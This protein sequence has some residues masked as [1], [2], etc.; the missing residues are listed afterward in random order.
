M[1][2]AAQSAPAGAP[3]Q[4]GA[5][6]PVKAANALATLSGTVTSVQGMAIPHVNV[7]LLGGGT[8]AVR[9]A[10]AD[11]QGRFTFPGLLPGTYQIVISAIGI[12]TYE[13]ARIV[14]AP[15]EER[16]LP[17]SQL[18]IEAT[19]TSV[20][21]YAEPDAVATAQVQ[22][23]EKQ[24]VLGIL[25]NF[26]TSYIWDAAPMSTKLKFKLAVR[27]L[28][29]P[30]AFLIAGGVAGVEQWH[31]TFPGYGRGPE[32]YAKR[33]GA[34]YGDNV[35]GRMVG[36]AILPSLFHQDPRYFYRGTGSIPSRT[37]Y[38]AKS[39]FITRG[40]NGRR[41]FNYSQIL[42]DFADSS[43]A[44]LYRTPQD[45]SASLTIR[46]SFIIVG[47]NVAG[48]IIREFLLHR[49]TPNLPNID[50]GKVTGKSSAATP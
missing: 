37:W 22:L 2:T 39:V 17:P 28:D 12:Q 43:F 1:E 36:S 25:P 13:S 47:T 21:V 42:G 32:G 18:A 23:A 27:T 10:V 20:Q 5:P 16:D 40:D 41:E 29:D 3:A 34:A 7:S 33:Y 50:K 26:Y 46:N 48:N 45:R 49:I 24:R 14:L 35:I 30:L 11:A 38:A 9:V 44:N 6:A 15:G 19:S 8:D 4:A 31:N